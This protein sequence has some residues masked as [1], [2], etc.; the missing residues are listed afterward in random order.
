M[1]TKITIILGLIYLV[2]AS[3]EDT[4][5][6]RFLKFKDQYNK[7]YPTLDGFINRFNIFK[8]NYFK[9]QTK[10]K[11]NSSSNVSGITKF[12]DLTPEEFKNM[13]LGVS[14]PVSAQQK[15]HR[16][17]KDQQIQDSPDKWDW[18]DYG[19]VGPVKN[20]D[21]CNADWVYSIIDVISSLQAINSGKFIAYSGQQVLDCIKGQYD[22]KHGYNEPALDYIVQQGGLETESD[23]PYTG[24]KDQCAFDEKKIA[25]KLKNKV[26]EGYLNEDSMQYILY[27][28]GPLSVRLNGEPLKDYTGGILDPEECDPLYNNSHAAVIGYGSENGKDFWIVKNYM[29]E[30][31]GER[32]YFRIVRGKEACGINGNIAA[33][34]LDD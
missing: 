5:F 29:G 33:A 26:I 13:Y 7:N 20:K 16:F 12:S 34:D 15:P 19:V 8:E 21:S 27:I 3:E 32:G 23:Y 25:V 9:L 10:I 14:N 24:H 31:W 11:A 4:I 22:C 28:A 17:I 30:D 6:Q 18:R 1:I 2:G